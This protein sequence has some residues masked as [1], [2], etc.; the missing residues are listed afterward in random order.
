[1]NTGQIIKSR[2][3]EKFVTLENKLVQSTELTLEEKGLLAYLLSLPS[4]WV[5]YKKNLHEKLNESKGTVDRVFKS[6]QEKGYIISVRVHDKTGAFTGWNHV[7]Y[8]SPYRDSPTSTNA[9]IGE[10]LPIQKTNSYTKKDLVQIKRLNFP[11]DESNEAWERWVK[12]R[13]EIK[14]SLTPSTAQMQLRKL[15]GVAPEVRVKMIDQS[16]QNG[17]TGLFEIKQ[18]GKT[19]YLN[20]IQRIYSGLE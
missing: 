3:S 10:S 16:I 9:D 6:L 2:S 11:D 19:D 12:Y 4:D 8:D 15:G 14:K 7:V 1:M 5:L 13:K 17:W 18:N 20:E